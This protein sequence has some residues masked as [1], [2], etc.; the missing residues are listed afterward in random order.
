MGGFLLGG[1]GAQWQ[2]Q[3]CLLRKEPRIPGAGLQ[4]AWRLVP[5]FLGP[6]L[7]LSD[8][9]VKHAHILVVPQEVAG[10]FLIVTCVCLVPRVFRPLEPHLRT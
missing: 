7:V 10:A 6:A 9:V 3:G 1:A 8:G 5:G 2:L 4:E